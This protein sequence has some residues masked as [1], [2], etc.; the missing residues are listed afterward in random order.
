MLTTGKKEDRVY[1]NLS[2][3]RIRNSGYPARIIIIPLFRAS[4]TQEE[5]MTGKSKEG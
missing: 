3:K 4:E 1:S 2:K 5:K